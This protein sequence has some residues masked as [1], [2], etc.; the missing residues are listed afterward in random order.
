MRKW[1]KAALLSGLLFPGIGHL[2]L[3]EYFRAS[4]LIVAAVAA[5]YVLTSAAVDQ[6]MSV[7][8]R[9]NSGDVAP[10]AQSISEAITASSAEADNRPRMRRS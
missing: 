7:V 9:V 8:D 3:K 4:I 1:T 2:A 5:V 10:D 6:A